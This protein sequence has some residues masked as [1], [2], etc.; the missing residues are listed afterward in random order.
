MA[1]GPRFGDA[2][3]NGTGNDE[4][5]NQQYDDLK[6]RQTRQYAFAGNDPAQQ[7]FVFKE[8]TKESL[9]NIRQRRLSK[10]KRISVANV[11]STK[12]KLEPDP[13]LASGVQLPQYI[14]RRVPPELIGKPIED[15]DP[16]YADKEVS[17]GAYICAK[18]FRENG[19]CVR[20]YNRLQLTN[21]F[22]RPC[23]LEYQL[24]RRS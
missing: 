24:D 7:Q 16:Y 12:Q 11:E 3:L 21:C 13:F 20:S 15:I 14:L 9:A 17:A 19:A 8:F 6:R 5:P 18:L 23:E 10:A 22:S 4:G 1:G 2:N